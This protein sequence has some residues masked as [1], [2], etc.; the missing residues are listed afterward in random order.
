MHE[1]LHDATLFGLGPLDLA[2]FEKALSL[3]R[4]GRAHPF[5]NPRRAVSLHGSYDIPDDKEMLSKA[6]PELKFDPKAKHLIIL[7]LKRDLRKLVREE[8]KAR[9]AAKA[10]K[11]KFRPQLKNVVIWSRVVQ[12][13]PFLSVTARDIRGR[14]KDLHVG[15]AAQSIDWHPVPFIF[16]DGGLKLRKKEDAE[17]VPEFDSIYRSP[18]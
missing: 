18:K 16:F 5:Q 6:I 14:A 2:R 3:Q 7:V 17:S 4:G 10:R 15:L 11:E 13:T 9:E 1:N 8:K 12:A